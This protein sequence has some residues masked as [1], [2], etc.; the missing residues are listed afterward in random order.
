[1]NPEETL[2]KKIAVI[3]VPA[4]AQLDPTSDK[5]FQ[6]LRGEATERRSGRPERGIFF[7]QL[8]ELIYP[9]V[10]TQRLLHVYGVPRRGCE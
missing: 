1:M 2:G 7:T 5:G 6:L 4:E 9:D 10:A 3:L 8:L